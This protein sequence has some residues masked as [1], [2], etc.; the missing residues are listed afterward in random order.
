MLPKSTFTQLSLNSL[1]AKRLRTKANEGL[2]FIS[3]LYKIETK[4]RDLPIENRLKYRLEESKPILDSFSAWLSEQSLLALPKSK[5]GQA[6]EYAINQW[7]YLK[8]YVLDGRLEID[9]NR[10]E[11]SIKLFVMGRKGWLFSNTP[12]GADASAV[13]YSIIVTAKEN[14]LKPFD[15]LKY[16]LEEIPS[17]E[18][19]QDE[20]LDHL[21]PWS[22]SLP[23]DI[24]QKK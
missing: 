2:N 16:L 19:I 21:L 20:G 1:N 5:L 3:Q 10:T 6:I 11:R 22:A 8:N 9:N 14:K 23:Q 7:D 13:I 18:N 24:K 4:I 17:F 15:Y 12:K